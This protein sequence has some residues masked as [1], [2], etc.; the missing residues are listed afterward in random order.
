M[1]YTPAFFKAVAP[2]YGVISAA[3]DKPFGHHFLPRATTISTLRDLGVEI[4]STSAEPLES[5]Y[6]TITEAGDLE[7]SVPDSPL[8]YWTCR[9][10]SRCVGTLDPV[11]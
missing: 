1:S 11:P 2:R 3:F 4:F 5:I 7:W 6:L 9:P 8:F 10:S